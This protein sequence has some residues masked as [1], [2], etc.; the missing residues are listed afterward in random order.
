MDAGTDTLRTAWQLRALR[1]SDLELVCRHREQLF[2]E[3]GRAPALVAQMRAP[4]REWLQ[5]HFAAGTYVGWIAERDGRAAGGAGFIELDWPP[6]TFHPDQAR[7][8]YVLNV[9]VEPEFRG[10]GCAKALMRAVESEMRARGID[11]CTLHATDAGRPLYDALGWNAT[12][13]MA[14]RLG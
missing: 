1:T 7:R 12:N 6:H 9:F 13:E 14:K 3:A 4:F 10:A 2:L 11:Y 8:G 5:R